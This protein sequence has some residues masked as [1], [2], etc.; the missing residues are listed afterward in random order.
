MFWRPAVK[1]A[2]DRGDFLLTHEKSSPLKRR[3]TNTTRK[4]LTGA[5]Q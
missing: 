4:T 2:F 1:R 3:A 5:Q